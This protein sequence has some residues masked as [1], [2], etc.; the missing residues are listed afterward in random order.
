V[1][2]RKDH[3]DILLRTGSSIWTFRLAWVDN[4][5]DLMNLKNQVG[6]VSLETVKKYRNDDVDPDKVERYGLDL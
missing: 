1:N 6:W 5:G 2:I 3:D 4:G